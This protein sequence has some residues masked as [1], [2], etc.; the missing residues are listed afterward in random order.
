MKH[1]L[2]FILLFSSIASFAQTSKKMDS[3]LKDPNRDIQAAKADVYLHRQQEKTVLFDSV[4]PA[5]NT[6]ADVKRKP[7]KKKHSK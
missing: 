6:P 5:K 4:S 1:F 3:F 2:L 7:L